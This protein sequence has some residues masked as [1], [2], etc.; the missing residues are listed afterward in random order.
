MYRLT[1]KVEI[2]SERRWEIRHLTA[3]EIERD[4]DS[5]TDTCKLTLPR[6]MR[7]DGQAKVP[8]A[9]G[10]S[11]RVWLGYD[12]GDLQ[13]AFV[14]YVRDV[15]FKSP[16]VITCEDEMYKLKTTPAKRLAYRTVSISKLLKDQNITTPIKVLG[17]QSLGQ[18]RVVADTVASLLGKL[19]DQGVRCFYRYEDGRAVLYAGILFDRAIEGG[20]MQALISGVNII[21]DTQLEQQRADTMRIKIKAISLQPNNKRIRVE[22]GDADGEL[23]TMHTYGRTEAETK[24]WAESELKRLKRDG[25]KGTITTFGARLVDKLDAIAIKIDGVRHGRYQ[26]AKCTIKYSTAGLRQDITLGQ[27]LS[28]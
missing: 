1:A 27:R 8:I 3:C 5:L 4:M 25:L 20:E 9:R 23:R 15:G 22:V 12:D 11:V 13:L 7:W 19:R 10:D 14:G 2:Q 28:D 6:R 21:S 16:I 18:Y 17:E 26:V 24:A